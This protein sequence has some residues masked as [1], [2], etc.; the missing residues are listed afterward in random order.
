[1]KKRSEQID[2]IEKMLRE[3]AEDERYKAYKQT[4]YC[5]LAV[6]ALLFFA[7]GVLI[8]YLLGA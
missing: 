7:L 1:M 8:R 4:C 3:N 5:N 6:K 2:D